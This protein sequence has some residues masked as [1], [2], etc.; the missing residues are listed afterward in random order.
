MWRSRAP[1]QQYLIGAPMENV[2]VNILGPFPVFRT[3][4]LHPQS[5]GL[6]E[7]LNCTLTKISDVV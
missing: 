5:D 1:L 2:G 7:R 3:T 4:P 6:V